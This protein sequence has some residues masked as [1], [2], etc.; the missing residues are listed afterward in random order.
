MKRERRVRNQGESH[1][2]NMTMFTLGNTVLL[3]R[4]RTSKLMNNTG[5]GTKLTK[6]I[7]GV[8]TTTIGSQ[9]FNISTKMIFH[10][11]FK[12]LKRCKNLRFV[13]QRKKTM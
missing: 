11:I 7:V 2:N 10:G 6:F 5:L 1:V 13:F 12:V 3:R 9:G 4:V 8:L